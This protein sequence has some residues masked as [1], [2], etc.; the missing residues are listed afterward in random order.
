MEENTLQDFEQYLK[1][2]GTQHELTVLKTPQQNEVAERMNRTLVETIMLMLADSELTKR[3]WA[4]ALSAVTYLRN[5]SPT[6]ALQD[7]T[8]YEAWNGN[9]PNV[10][11][12]RI[13][14]CDAYG[15]V[16]KDE[17]SKFDS[18]TRRSI[19]LGYGQGV[20]GYRLYDKA[21]RRIFYSRNVVFNETSS[22]KQDDLKDVA[23]D[24]PSIELEMDCQS[25]DDNTIKHHADEEPRQERREKRPPD[26]YG[27]SVYIAQEED[28]VIVKEALSSQD[29]AKWRKAMETE[30][31]SLHKNQVWELSELTPGK[32]NYLK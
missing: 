31:Q 17:R 8:A 16:P 27:E 6:T 14:G 30:L 3:F 32:K 12:L 24:E 25:E 20:K 1:K 4:E 10:S 23:E 29:V 26:S 15:H 11:H 5:R 19:F 28:H 2:Q 13:F 22:T 21:Q 9:K 18:K 7:K